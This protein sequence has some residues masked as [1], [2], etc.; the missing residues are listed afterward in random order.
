VFNS[1]RFNLAKFLATLVLKEGGTSDSLKIETKYFIPLAQ[2]ISRLIISDQLSKQ[3]LMEK[4]ELLIGYQEAQ[5]LSNTLWLQ[6]VSQI[7]EP[8]AGQ[9][10][11]ADL[12]KVI[13]ECKE[14]E[15]KLDLIS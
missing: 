6:F 2:F 13:L 15:A 14:D 11:A 5:W 7:S 10:K 9:G 1:K 12:Q 4:L 8:L 3:E